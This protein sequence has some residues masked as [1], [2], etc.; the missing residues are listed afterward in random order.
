MPDGVGGDVHIKFEIDRL[1]LAVHFESDR[2]FFD[3]AAVFD[4]F[5]ATGCESANAYGHKCG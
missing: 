5:A 4:S 2:A 1:L 3:L